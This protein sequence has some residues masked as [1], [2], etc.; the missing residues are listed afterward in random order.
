[1]SDLEADLDAALIKIESL[2]IS[3]NNMIDEIEMWSLA[4][5]AVMPSNIYI[6]TFYIP[7]RLR[8]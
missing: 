2:E 6:P 8:P 4:V 1:M 7:S 5:Q 3:M